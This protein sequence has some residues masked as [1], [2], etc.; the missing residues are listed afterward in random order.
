MYFMCC[1]ALCK[2]YSL[3]FMVAEMM[4]TNFIQSRFRYI[5]HSKEFLKKKCSCGVIIIEK[6]SLIKMSASFQNN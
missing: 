1:Y 2:F 6:S 4:L 5:K 3:I